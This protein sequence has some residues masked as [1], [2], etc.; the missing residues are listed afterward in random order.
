MNSASL[1][2]DRRLSLYVILP[3]VILNIGALVVYAGYYGMKY[4]RPEAMPSI[5]EY[6][7]SLITYGMIFIV[8]WVFALGVIAW[9]RRN[10]LP[11]RAL[12][13]PAAAPPFR[14]GPALAM[15]LG[16]N[17][18]FVIYFWIASRIYGDLGASYRGLP[19]WGQMF[20]LVLLPITAAFCEELIWR[21][22]IL[23]QFELRGY[24]A[25]KAILLMSLSF[26]LI[27]GI[28]LV[29]K[30]VVTFLVG[31]IAG[32]YYWKERNLIP[33][34]VAHWLLDVWGYGIFVLG[35]F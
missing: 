16:I 24:G 15:G 34:I 20:L 7:L 8:E 22:H 17:L 13:K 30:L 11:L 1:P 3:A 2:R 26:A 19:V 4:A 29:D 6:R 10:H 14:W 25:W 27:H 18:L 23:T 33:V 35:W 9:L 28:F 32:W 5:P 12:V 21:G 31:I